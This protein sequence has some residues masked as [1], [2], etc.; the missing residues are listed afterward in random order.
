MSKGTHTVL[1]PEA[2]FEGNL[3]FEGDVRID[4]FFKGDIVSRDR[5]IVGEGARIEGTVRV[6]TL[7]LNG[8]IEGRV[9]AT[10]GAELEAPGRL[11]G[12]LHTASLQVARGV[13]L[14]G[15]VHMLDQGVELAVVPEEPV[16]IQGPLLSG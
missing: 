13:V 16:E 15:S 3:D 5:L 12:E 4:G 1:G 6:G 2:R 10:Q 8:V 7:V 11:V 14:D 9:I